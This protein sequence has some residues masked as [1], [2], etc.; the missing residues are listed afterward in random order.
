MR[1]A[2]DIGGTFTDLVCLEFDK[3]TGLP[4]GVKVAKSDTT[5][6]NFEQGILDTIKKGGVNLKATALNG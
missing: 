3:K 2:T 6:A 4:T 1:I 5:P